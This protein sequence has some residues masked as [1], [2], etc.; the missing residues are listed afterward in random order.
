MLHDIL[1]ITQET[2]ST[3]EIKVEH[4]SDWIFK[5]PFLV[6]NELESHL[7]LLGSWVWRHL[8]TSDCTSLK[9]DQIQRGI[10]LSCA[11]VLAC[12][13]LENLYHSSN[14]TY[15]LA[16]FPSFWI[17]NLASD[18][19]AFTTECTQTIVSETK[20]NVTCLHVL[21]C[22]YCCCLFL[23]HIQCQGNWNS[24]QPR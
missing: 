20:S 2:P 3:K 23:C 10:A 8:Y 18:S 7:K 22:T 17:Q 13:L 14:A 12:V 4:H 1:C 21:L 6:L 19:E 24:I 16:S 11:C 15:D 9:H 5:L